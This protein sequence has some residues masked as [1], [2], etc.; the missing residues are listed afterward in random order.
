[1]TIFGGAKYMD[2][3]IYKSLFSYNEAETSFSVMLDQANFLCELCTFEN[4]MATKRTQNIFSA[5]SKV[6]I[7]DSSMYI[8]QEYFAAYKKKHKVDQFYGSFLFLGIDS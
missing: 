5:F 2:T 1:M 3:T 8:E 6:S 7:I 4:N